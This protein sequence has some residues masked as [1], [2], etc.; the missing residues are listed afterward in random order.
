M[1]ARPRAAGTPREPADP[2]RTLVELT[3]RGSEQ[4]DRS[5]AEYRQYLNRAAW[6]SA[7]RR[8]AQEADDTD[9]LA[10]ARDLLNPRERPFSLDVGAE[11]GIG[12]GGLASGY[13]LAQPT[14]SGSNGV[15]VLL[16]LLILFASAAIKHVK[17]Q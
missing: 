11:L 8:G 4:I 1:A 10:G 6:L 2:S 5:V 9:V 13:G 17:F 16:G 12:I 14:W 3:P 15:V 7:R